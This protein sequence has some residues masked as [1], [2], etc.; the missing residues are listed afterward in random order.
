MSLEIHVDAYSGHKAN[1]RPIC[2]WLDTTLEESELMGVFEI[3][4]IEDR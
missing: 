3:E 2:F 1:E 4:M